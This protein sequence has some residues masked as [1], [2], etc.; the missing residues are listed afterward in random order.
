MSDYEIKIWDVILVNNHRTPIIYIKPDL[1]FIEFIRQNNFEVIVVIQG[2]NLP[3]DGN[4]IRG[5]VNESSMTP[6]CRPNFFADTGLFVV[7]LE[8]SWNG[9]PS[10]QNLGKVKFF[11]SGFY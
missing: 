8:S 9:Y 10:E 7:Q 3:Y 1:A 2:T 6:C 4:K 5:I 11:S